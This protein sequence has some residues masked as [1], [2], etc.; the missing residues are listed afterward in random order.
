M[1]S[2]LFLNPLNGIDHIA[3]LYLKKEKGGR[4]H[5]FQNQKN[6]VK[7]KMISEI[8]SLTSRPIVPRSGRDPYSEPQ[9]SDEVKCAI[10]KPPIQ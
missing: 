2:S 6:K 3:I 5:F 9:E 7:K 4:N 10:I 1:C 8:V